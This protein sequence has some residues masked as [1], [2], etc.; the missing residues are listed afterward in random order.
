MYHFTLIPAQLESTQMTSAAPQYNLTLLNDMDRWIEQTWAR[1]RQMN[2][3]AVD[4]DAG[5]AELETYK[6]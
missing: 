5:N 6:V 1:L 4:E 2:S 3:G